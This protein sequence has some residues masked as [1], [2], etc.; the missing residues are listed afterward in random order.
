MISDSLVLGLTDHGSTYRNEE[1]KRRDSVRSKSQ[2]KGKI[3]LDTVHRRGVHCEKEKDW[4][5]GS[6]FGLCALCESR[7]DNLFTFLIK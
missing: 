7:S 2:P 6:C 4:G 3:L 5:R 1:G